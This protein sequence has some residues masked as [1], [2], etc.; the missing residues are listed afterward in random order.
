MDKEPMM[1][2][3]I[4]HIELRKVLPLYVTALAAI[5]AYVLFWPR[6]LLSG[7]MIM[8]LAGFVQGFFITWIIFRDAPTVE[9][10]LLSRGITRH[11]WF[12]HRWALAVGLVLLTLLIVAVVISAGLRCLIFINGPWHPMVKWYELNILWSLGLAGAVGI[13]MRLFTLLRNRF[14]RNYKEPSTRR[15]MLMFLAIGAVVV[16]LSFVGFR[17]SGSNAGFHIPFR[18]IFV[19]CL[20][21]AGLL[22]LATGSARSCFLKMEIHT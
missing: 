20:Y 2:K 7:N 16:C 11:K 1:N 19:V 12:W 18:F 21:A 22:V 14:F 13:S 9:C 6:P 10:F 8:V 3:S 17:V 4:L 15:V 5:I